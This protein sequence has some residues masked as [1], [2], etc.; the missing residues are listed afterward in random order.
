MDLHNNGKKL[1]YHK[2]YTKIYKMPTTY[3]KLFDGRSPLVS[4]MEL[5]GKTARVCRA[6]SRTI[7][8][9]LLSQIGRLLYWREQIKAIQN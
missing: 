7:V 2:G 4:I 6:K 9:V 5:L 1:L 8:L 3:L